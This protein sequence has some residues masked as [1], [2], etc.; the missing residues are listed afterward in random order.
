MG[1]STDEIISYDSTLITDNIWSGSIL[2]AG[3]VWS[4]DNRP[5]MDMNM[6]HLECS[7]SIRILAGSTNP[8]S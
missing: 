4:A 5:G 1:N 2:I 7:D 6:R 8:P 3:Y